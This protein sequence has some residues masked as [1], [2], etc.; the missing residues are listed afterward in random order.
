MESIDF[1]GKPLPLFRGFNSPTYG[2]SRGD[3]Q[4][5]AFSEDS[6][7]FHDLSWST[8]FYATRLPR[9]YRFQ[10]IYYH[11]DVGFPVLDVL[12]PLSLKEDGLVVASNEEVFA[13]VLER[14]GRDFRFAFW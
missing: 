4:V 13:I 9:I 14:Y 5:A 3:A 10:V 12:V 1:L 6:L 11:G 2:D 8:D 7:M